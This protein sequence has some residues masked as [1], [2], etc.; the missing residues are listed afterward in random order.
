MDEQFIAEMFT[1]LTFTLG[2]VTIQQSP[3]PKSPSIK[4][5]FGSGSVIDWPPLKMLAS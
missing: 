1:I 4:V 2:A 3:G 5:K